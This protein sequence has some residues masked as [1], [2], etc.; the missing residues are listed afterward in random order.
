MNMSPA[1]VDYGSEATPVTRQKPLE[2]KKS[3]KK[4]EKKKDTTKK[5]DNTE[6]I[7]ASNIDRLK[8]YMSLTGKDLSTSKKDLAITDI[9]I[10]EEDF[11]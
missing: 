7:K 4:E 1:D 9:S 10:T 6:K 8:S 11:T 5:T 3:T 2:K